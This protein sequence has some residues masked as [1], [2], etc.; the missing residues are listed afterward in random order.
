[1]MAKDYVCPR[2][3]RGVVR[4]VHLARLHH[5]AVRSPIV[6]VISRTQTEKHT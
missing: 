4:Q 1:M 5:G 6:G 2:E 3:P